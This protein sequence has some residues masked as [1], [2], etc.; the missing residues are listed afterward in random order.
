M[1]QSLVGGF[2]PR[3]KFFGVSEEIDSATDGQIA[4]RLTNAELV[5]R[6]NFKLQRAGNQ[7]DGFR[8]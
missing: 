6:R 4:G 2:V 5:A 3:D 8:L 1:G 7:E